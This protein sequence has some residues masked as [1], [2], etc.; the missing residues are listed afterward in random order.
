[1]SNNGQGIIDKIIFDAKADAEA[2]INKAKAEADKIID[3]AN[4]KAQKQ[5]NEYKAQAEIDAATVHSKEISAADLQA[6]QSLLKLK[7]DYIEQCVKSAKEK[8][9]NMP[10][11]EYEKTVLLMLSAD[12]NSKDYEVIVSDEKLKQ[13]L[14]D[15]GYKVSDEKRKISRGFI[16]KN[17]D[18]EYNYVFDSIMTIE[19][20]EIEQTASSVLFA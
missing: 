20:E 6:R 7:Q 19:K 11:E 16:L 8:L 15:A 1:M 18:I 3:D 17:G 4:K 12:K 14:K 5:L 10:F 9:E 2:V 13:S